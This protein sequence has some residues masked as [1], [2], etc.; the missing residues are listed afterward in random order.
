MDVQA[1]GICYF[2]V[3][4][5][6]MLTIKFSYNIHLTCSL[7]VIEYGYVYIIDLA[8]QLQWFFHSEISLNILS[9][10]ISKV[11]TN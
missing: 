6:T 1:T 8:Y 9:I 5:Q 4:K 7:T 2:L 10:K 3:L 11:F